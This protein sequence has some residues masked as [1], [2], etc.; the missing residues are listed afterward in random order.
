MIVGS[1]HFGAIFS[2]HLLTFMLI[3]SREATFGGGGEGDLCE[4]LSID[5]PEQWL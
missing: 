2:P 5:K 1:G 4:L 3:G